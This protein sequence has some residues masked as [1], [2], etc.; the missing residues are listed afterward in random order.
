[1]AD[2]VD[3]AAN[4]IRFD[5]H[6]TVTA[7]TTDLAHFMS[8]DIDALD[9]DEAKFSHPQ[10]IVQMSRSMWESLGRP[11]RVVCGVTPTSWE[12]V[13]GGQHA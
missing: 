2:I 13:T 7:R 5:S 8:L 9:P 1:M 3:A 4:S 10:M 11:S 6:G 12:I